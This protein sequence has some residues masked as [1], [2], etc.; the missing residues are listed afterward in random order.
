MFCVKLIEKYEINAN[1]ISDIDFYINIYFVG[2]VN[3]V[4]KN[5]PLFNK[6]T[7]HCPD[8]AGEHKLIFQHACVTWRG[9]SSRASPP[10]LASQSSSSCN[11]NIS[12]FM[13][14]VTIRG[15][16]LVVS[17]WSITVCYLLFTFSWSGWS[18]SNEAKNTST[19][20]IVMVL[21]GL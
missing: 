16:N 15:T 4:D 12:Q 18:L 5:N 10:V 3:F 7:G 8:C 17:W 6:V 21:V 14:I 20:C 11:Q 2:C 1:L 9:N 13:N 19:E